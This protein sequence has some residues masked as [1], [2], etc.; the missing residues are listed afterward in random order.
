MHHTILEHISTTLVD[1]CGGYCVSSKMMKLEDARD[2][3]T[4]IYYRWPK[5]DERASASIINDKCFFQWINFSSKNIIKFVIFFV[6]HSSNLSF[7]TYMSTSIDYHA[8][9]MI[10]AII[11]LSCIASC[12]YWCHRIFYDYFTIMLT[13]DETTYIVAVHTVTTPHVGLYV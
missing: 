4:N 5:E 9:I 2:Y 11:R 1:F 7:N 12:K 13:I 8:T 10:I 3:H 6:M